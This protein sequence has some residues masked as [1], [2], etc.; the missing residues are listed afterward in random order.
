MLKG[1]VIEKEEVYPCLKCAKDGQVVLFSGQGKGM[2][3]VKGDIGYSVGVYLDHWDES[4]FM[5]ITGPV[6]VEEI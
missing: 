1:T 6:T 4:M 2:C 3:L 5:H